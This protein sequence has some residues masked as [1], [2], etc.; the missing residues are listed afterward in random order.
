MRAASSASHPRMLAMRSSTSAGVL[1][2]SAAIAASSRSFTGT[3]LPSGSCCRTRSVPR[4]GEDSCSSEPRRNIATASPMVSLELS[5]RSAGTLV[6][7]AGTSA[8]VAGGTSS[9]M[10]TP[11]EPARTHR[12]L[13]GIGA[14]PR[15]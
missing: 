10:S 2:R 6:L 5:L 1:P 4:C 8:P 7:G 14:L 3:R 12:S 9:L 15:S 13:S 11:I